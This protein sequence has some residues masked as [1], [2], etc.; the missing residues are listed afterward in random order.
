MVTHGVGLPWARRAPASWGRAIY[1][2]GVL[3]VLRT[4]FAPVTIEHADRLAGVEGPLVIVANHVS[5]ADTMC[6]A[7]ALPHHIRRHFVV[8]AAADYFFASNATAALSTVF[9]GAIPVDRSRVSRTTLELCHQLLGEGNSLLVY[10]EGGRSHDGEMHEFKPGAA[11]IAR[12]AGV[13]VLPLHLAGTGGILPKG[14]RVPRRAKVSVVV[15][16]LV[17]LEPGEDAKAFNRRI[18]AAVRALA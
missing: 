10:P 3:R 16:D 7:A 2:E 4:V 11:W 17:H 15:G 13:P 18:E 5:H 12:R 8:A 14:R 6:L 1:Y 9:V